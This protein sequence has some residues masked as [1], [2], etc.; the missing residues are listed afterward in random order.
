MDPGVSLRHLI[1]HSGK[2]PR[3]RRCFELITG[4]Y[5]FDPKTAEESDQGFTRLAGFTAK[6]CFQLPQ[7]H[8]GETS[9]EKRAVVC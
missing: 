2:A 8:S 3:V 4:D 1:F 9:L 7:V 5:L 6:C